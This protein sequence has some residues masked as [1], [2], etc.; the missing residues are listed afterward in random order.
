MITPIE[1]QNLSEDKQEELLA[2]KV[3]GKTPLWLI[4]VKDAIKTNNPLLY[5]F[6]T[7]NK[8]YLTVMNGVFDRGIQNRANQR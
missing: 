6:L 5:G 1:F 3:D 7:D 4:Q 8:E 2:R